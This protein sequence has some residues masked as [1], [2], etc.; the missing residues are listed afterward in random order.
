M[1]ST[2]LSLADGRL[3]DVSVTG[4]DT[5]MPVVF[6]HGTP[7]SDV[8]DR[9][10]RR[11]VH[12]RGL[13]LVTLSRPGY[14]TSS[15]RRARRVVDVVDDTRAVLDHVG[16]DRCLVAGWS[17]GGPHALAC[18]ARLEAATGVLVIAGVAPARV[19]GL[20]W[21]AGMGEENVVEFT[22]ALQ[23][24]AALGPYLESLHDDFANVTAAHV[25]EALSTVLP[26]VDRRVL[27][28][29]FGEDVAS[30]FRRAVQCGVEGWLDDDLAFTSDWGFSVSE[31]SVPTVLWHGELDLM[32]PVAHGRWLA[33]HVPG[34][35]A[36]LVPDEG[37]LSLAVGRFPEML[38]ELLTLA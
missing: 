33:T 31:V 8:A 7:G 23:G 15:R 20:D 38:D 35:R 19:A 28:E 37:H 14:G 4:P 21:M 34:V 25:V 9:S 32:V 29:E 6:H 17:G 12:E 36:H 16:A 10:L 22:R 26:D 11:A 13:R 3:L 2:S 27:T 18:G 1:T 24:E 30:S 5:G